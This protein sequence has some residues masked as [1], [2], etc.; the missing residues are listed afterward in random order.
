MSSANAVTEKNSAASLALLTA[1]DLD[2]SK[3]PTSPSTEGSQGKPVAV[4]FKDVVAN[5]AGVEIEL[6]GLTASSPYD[7]TDHRGTLVG[8]TALNTTTPSI[9]EV[10]G[11]AQEDEDTVTTL[12]VAIV[13]SATGATS[14][15]NF[16]SPIRAW[17]DANGKLYLKGAPPAAA[18]SAY[19]YCVDLNVA[20][21]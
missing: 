3:I 2:T 7:I 4:R 10:T 20:R 5:Y 9:G 16:A 17:S 14:H 18:D 8:G 12:S 11:F 6:T 15:D 19:H 1:I 21:V 13:T